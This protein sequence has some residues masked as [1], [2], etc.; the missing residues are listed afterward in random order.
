MSR[1]PA[2]SSACLEKLSCLKSDDPCNVGFTCFPLSPARKQ[3]PMMK[4]QTR[5]VL[6]DMPD[7]SPEEQCMQILQKLLPL[8]ELQRPETTTCAQELLPLQQR[9]SVNSSSAS[10]DSTRGPNVPAALLGNLLPIDE[11][12]QGNTVEDK[13]LVRLLKD[14]R[15]WN[16]KTFP[17][18]E[19][20][21]RL[22]RSATA[23]RL[24]K[25][26]GGKVVFVLDD[27]NEAA[28]RRLTMIPGRS[29]KPA[30]SRIQVSDH[31]PL[32]YFRTQLL[33]KFVTMEDAFE[34]IFQRLTVHQ[35]DAS[36]L[37]LQEFY[38][39]VQ[40]HGLR[41]ASQG[42]IIYELLDANKDG[43]LSLYELNVGVQC[44]APVTCAYSLRRRLL[45]L[46]FPS[47]RTALSAMH[48]P[49]GL[50]P[51]DTTNCPLPF[52]SFSEAL[53]RAYILE[54]N[55][56]R[57]IFD[58][59]RD[60]NDPQG[61]C[62]LSE[63]FCGLA[64]VSP[65][66]LFEDVRVLCQSKFGSIDAAVT[67]WT[68][69]SQGNFWHMVATTL[70]LSCEESIKLAS[71]FDAN[72]STDAIIRDLRSMLILTTPMVTLED[73]RKQL[74]LCFRS[75]ELALQN[76][77]SEAPEFLLDSQLVFTCEELVE[78]FQDV[79][80]VEP[81]ITRIIKFIFKHSEGLSLA[82]F[83]KWVRLLVPCQAL[84]AVRCQLGEKYS[85]PADA[86][87]KVTDRRAFFIEGCLC[88]H[89]GEGW[90]CYNRGGIAGCFPIGGYQ[91]FRRCYCD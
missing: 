68:C 17:L 26:V 9:C 10:R 7:A 28:G 74:Q 22:V 48:S 19:N 39:R 4:Y 20:R 91:T 73:S 72:G 40:A 75:I 81:S 67:A 86:F 13:G 18:V 58:L 21:I 79:A 59:V 1:L 44:T 15:Q 50:A 82:R 31:H 46:G 64:S 8:P 11:C 45:C 52:Q 71:F 2:P 49:C 83:L 3:I 78:L 53:S 30:P 88:F 41:A 66:L 14:G 84:E 62:S 51:E 47:M 56:H 61:L 65:S 87:K 80:G 24:E 34:T 55:E 63:L 6:A 23:T 16:P 5:A 37:E 69:V 43:R 29:E 57:A 38:S 89:L 77:F 42:R 33:D 54:P 70:G 32:Q 35:D 76:I 85:H 25:D 27:P 12:F 36:Y 90:R 60:K